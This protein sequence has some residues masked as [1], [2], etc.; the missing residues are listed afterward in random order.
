M[1]QQSVQ[2][3]CPLSASVE[4]DPLGCLCQQHVCPACRSTS[5]TALMTVTSTCW[6]RRCSPRGAAV[7][8]R[9]PSC[10]ECS[11]IGSRAACLMMSACR[12]WATAT[13]EVRAADSCKGLLAGSGFT[14]HSAGNWTCRSE[15]QPLLQLGGCFRACHW[16]SYCCFLQASCVLWT[17]LITRSFLHGISSDECMVVGQFGCNGQSRL[18]PPCLTLGGEAW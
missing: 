2:L 5:S 11:W 4:V 17:C 6:R 16:S 14:R 10:A 1:A 3:G 9:T 18:H 13:G 12:C 7:G 15:H 8:P